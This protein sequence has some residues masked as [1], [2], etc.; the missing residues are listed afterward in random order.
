MLIEGTSVWLLWIIAESQL[1]FLFLNPGIN[2]F[3]YPAIDAFLPG[4]FQPVNLSLDYR[5]FLWCQHDEMVH[6]HDREIGAA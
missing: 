6:L 2:P 3:R 1:L 4:L 5:Y